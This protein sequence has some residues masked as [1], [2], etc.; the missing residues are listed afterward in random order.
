MKKIYSLLIAAITV[1]SAGYAQNYNITPTTVVNQTI[2]VGGYYSDY[3]Y[4]EHDNSSANQI[5]L[6]WELLSSNAPGDWDYSVCDYTNCYT[7]QITTGTMTPIGQGQSGFIAMNLM[8]G[9]V[10]QV[11]FIFSVWKMSDP[12]AKDTIEFHYNAVLGIEDVNALQ[13]M[14]IY[15]NPAIELLN[16]ANLVPGTRI[17]VLDALGN[18]V[19]EFISDNTSMT[20]N[21]DNLRMGVYFIKAEADNRKTII[22]K[23]IVK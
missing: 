5:T 7:G 16:L 18:K 15:P 2:E 11:D 1:S 13:N 6:Q 20:I 10:A 17:S 9:S 3:I 14:S 12:G 8:A 4:M 21:V 19:K 23:V 22:R